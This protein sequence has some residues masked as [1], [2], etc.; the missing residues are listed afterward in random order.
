M[1]FNY[2]FISLKI[3]RKLKTIDM[4]KHVYYKLSENVKPF[5]IGCDTLKK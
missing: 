3:H 1:Y 4:N 2:N 5:T